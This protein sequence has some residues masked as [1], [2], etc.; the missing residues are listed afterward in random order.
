MHWG[1]TSQLGIELWQGQSEAACVVIATVIVHGFAVAILATG[2]K[3]IVSDNRIARMDR[4]ND[5]RVSAS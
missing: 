3:A 2:T 5:M 4:C 1:I